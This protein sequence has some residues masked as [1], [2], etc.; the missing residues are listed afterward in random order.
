[1]SSC[2]LPYQLHD[3]PHHHSDVVS[4]SDTHF[5]CVRHLISALVAYREM[6]LC[7]NHLP[8]SDAA[9]GLALTPESEVP[10]ISLLTSPLL[11]PFKG[12]ESPSKSGAT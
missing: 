10:Q 9:G 4:R 7:L 1:M 2:I 8:L 5:S 12:A 6:L 11:G 3:L